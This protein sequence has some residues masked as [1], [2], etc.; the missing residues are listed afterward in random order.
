VLL[1]PEYV[2]YHHGYS[3]LSIAAVSISLLPESLAYPW[4]QS[5]ILNR[6][7]IM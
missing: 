2:P 3:K 1:E 4:L 5:H 7:L 6:S